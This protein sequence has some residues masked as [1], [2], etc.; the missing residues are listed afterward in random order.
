MKKNLLTLLISVYVFFPF[1]TKAQGLST[2][3]NL[4]I[5]I[6]ADNSLEWL[7]GDKQFVARGSAKAAQGLSSVEASTLTAHYRESPQSSMEIYRLLADKNVILKNENT[8]AYG[9]N[10]IYDI[11]DGLAILTGEDLKLESPDQTITAKERFE[12]FINEGRATAIGNARVIRPKADRSGFDTLEA[13]TLSAIFKENDTGET[14]LERMEAN[15]NVIITTPTEVVT[16]TYG[17]YT[18]STNIATLTGNV[19][20]KRGPNILE[21]DRAEVDLNTNVSKIFGSEK[22]SGRV[23]GTFFPGSAKTDSP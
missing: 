5:E 21:G 1:V 14:V 4:P 20:I 11:D 9:D 15:G 7:R 6:T 19:T 8:T 3:S 2:N 16:G 13:D 12:Y 22:Q 10:A 18:A 23:K 17:T